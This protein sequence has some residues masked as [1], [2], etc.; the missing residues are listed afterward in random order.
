VIVLV[1]FLWFSSVSLS[2]ICDVGRSILLKGLKV[3]IYFFWFH[4]SRIRCIG[5]NCN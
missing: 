5:D 1:Y 4:F 3:V 2:V